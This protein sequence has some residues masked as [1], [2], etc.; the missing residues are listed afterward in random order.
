MATNSSSNPSES[1][2]EKSPPSASV[3]LQ[4]PGE[5][6]KVFNQFDTAHF[7]NASIEEVT[8]TLIE[9]V[10]IVVIVIFFISG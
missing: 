6:Q 5:L 4:D 1:K 2:K 9:A 10:L 7:V 3:Y 8:T